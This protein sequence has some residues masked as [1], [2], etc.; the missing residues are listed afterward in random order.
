M[1]DIAREVPTR[2]GARRH[3]TALPA[4]DPADW[5]ERAAAAVLDW[6]NDWYRYGLDAYGEIVHG[7]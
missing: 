7:A 3:L 4:D 1:S 6:P 2:A 5:L